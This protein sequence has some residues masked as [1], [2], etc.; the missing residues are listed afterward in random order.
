VMVVV[1]EAIV[2]LSLLIYTVRAQPDPHKS[3]TEKKETRKGRAGHGNNGRVL[4]GRSRNLR[5]INS[6]SHS[7]YRSQ[8][9]GQR[10][11]KKVR[12]RTRKNLS[13]SYPNSPE[14]LWLRLSS[15]EARARRLRYIEKLKRRSM[16]VRKARQSQKRR[17]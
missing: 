2:S 6:A 13:H 12:P 11:C 1:L 16:K 3:S 7:M 8:A 10:E 17:C 9:R 14:E 15:T 5:R 4:L